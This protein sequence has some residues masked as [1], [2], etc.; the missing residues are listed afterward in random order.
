MEKKIGIKGK[1]LF[2]LNLI[3]IIIIFI[4]VSLGYFFEKNLHNDLLSETEEEIKLELEQALSSKKDVWIT[5]AL[6]IASNPLIQKSVYDKDRESLINFLDG[7]S[8]KF[9][10]N[11]NFNNISVHI[12]DKDLKSFV[13]SWNNEYGEDLS[14]SEIFNE[15]KKSK[16]PITSIERSGKGLRLKSVTPLFYEEKFIGLVDF[17]GGLNSIKRDLKS[18]D[19]EF[20][21]FGNM[22]YLGLK[23]SDKDVKWGPN[24]LMQK[25]IN[26][27]FLSETLETLE[28]EESLDEFVL[29]NK[30]YFIS[31]SI[32]SIK[33]EDIGVYLL[34]REKKLVDETFSKTFNILKNLLIIFVITFVIQM[35]LIYFFFSRYITKPID[36]LISIIKKGVNGD[37]SVRSDN[38]TED[39]IGELSSYFNIFIERIDKMILKIRNVVMD[40]STGIEDLENASAQV[41]EG[42]EDLAEASNEQAASIQETS[43]NLEETTSIINTNKDN[44]KEAAKLSGSAKN[45]AKEGNK[46]MEKMLVAMKEIRESSDEI[47]KIIKTIDDIA[48]QTNILA[49]N[50][51]V[52]AGR[53]GDAGSG[54]AVVAEE[55]RNL[56]ARSAEAAKDT[57][58][59]IEDSVDRSSRGMKIAKNVD[60]ALDEIQEKNENVNNIMDEI[61]IASE[62]QANGIEE[63]NTAISELEKAIQSISA[64]SQESAASSEELNAQL[65]NMNQIVKELEDLANGNENKEITEKIKI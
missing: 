15:V 7:L 23:S 47:S 37:L 42:G 56:A 63:I 43:S 50:A 27:D 4:F 22:N 33:G 38:N 10:N 1:M 5:N 57:T 44:V 39:E 53:A 24:V 51:A 18:K 21:F 62:E 40:I 12:I 13:K 61:S 48:F 8:E 58:E 52:E 28:V 6:Q 25:D 64:T 31:Q 30:Y 3:G 9:K 45:A 2:F 29:K 16:K 36:Q 34:G 35:L 14:Y 65:E 60:R 59:M 54:F 26:N 11:T 41:A 17:E 46:E 55:V 49:L 20:L 19:I 32:E